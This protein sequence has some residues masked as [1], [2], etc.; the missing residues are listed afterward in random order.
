MCACVRALHADLQWCKLGKW[1]SCY[2]SST[3]HI[4]HCSTSLSKPYSSIQTSLYSCFCFALTLWPWLPARAASGTL[5]S[6]E[7]VVEE[8]FKK[9]ISD[10]EVWPACLSLTLCL[11]FEVST[12]SVFAS[13]V[14]CLVQRSMLGFISW[15]ASQLRKAQHTDYIRGTHSHSHSHN[16]ALCYRVR[17]IRE[18]SS[19]L[20]LTFTST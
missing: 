2:F 18:L 17:L 10:C 9:F 6:L 8:A 11:K 16:V 3:Q 12:W 7:L 19:S 14:L 1:G 5:L 15:V 13:F 4:H 20:W